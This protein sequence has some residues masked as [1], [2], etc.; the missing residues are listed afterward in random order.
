MVD[1]YAGGGLKGVPRGQVKRLR[2]LSP[3]Y[4]YFGNAG[5]LNIAIDGPWDVQ[6]I[7]GTVPVHPDGSAYFRV[8]AN[9]PISVQPL[10]AEGKAIQ[11]MRSWFTAMPGEIKACVGCHEGAAATVPNIRAAGLAGPPDDITP[12]YGPARGLSFERDVQPVLDDHCVS[13]HNGQPQPNGKQLCDLRARRFFPDYEG[14]IAPIPQ[15]ITNGQIAPDITMDDVGVETCPLSERRQQRIQFTP[16]YEALHP[17]VRRGGSESDAHMLAP[18]EF[19]A[20]TSELVQMLLKGHYGTQLDAEAWDRL[21]TWID[22]NVPCHGTWHEVYPI[23]FNGHERR[24]EYLKLY[25]GI[26]EDYEAIPALPGYKARPAVSSTSPSSTATGAGTGTGRPGVPGFPFDVQEAKERQAAAASLLG[27]PI[28]RSVALGNGIVLE[29]VLIPAGEFVMGE[30]QGSGDEHPPSPVQITRPFW[31]GKFEVRNRDYAGFDPTHDSGYISQLGTGVESRGYPVN[32]PDQPVV[33]VS[34]KEA[35]AFCDWLSRKTGAKFSLPTEAQWEY[36]C[37]AGTA[38]ALWYGGDKAIFT[39]FGNMADKKLEELARRTPGKMLHS[40]HPDWVL[41][42]NR[43]FDAALVT[44]NVGNYLPN[45]WGLHD[46]HGNAAEWTRTTHRPYPYRADDGRDTPNEDG[47]K[48]VRGGSWYDLPK[49]CASAY[50]LSYP[51]WQGVYNVGFR[52]VC[53]VEQ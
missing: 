29:L 4:G 27:V 5:W 2:L 42:D 32:G 45:P 41:R 52:V 49:R 48:V 14:V 37:R 44:T 1:V 23:P 22:L 47:R 8:P 16:A 17:Y 24:Q 30:A 34:C 26:D 7:L 31:M 13:C 21:V 19:H 15:V 38:S 28:Q 33:R 25:A 20:D 51:P 11:L 35:M 18:Y 53:E 9:T 46:L 43:S 40:H 50:R 10:D 39:P 6:R 3:H 12:W 36:A